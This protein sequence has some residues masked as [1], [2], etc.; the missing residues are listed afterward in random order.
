MHADAVVALIAIGAAASLAGM[1]WPFPR[2]PLGVA[3]NFAAGIVGALVGGLLG[4]AVVRPGAGATPDRM[5]FAAA[6]ALVVLLAI[7][8]VALRRARSA[9]ARQ[10]HP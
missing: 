7:H 3:L 10:R 1:I 5:L 4:F 9:H 6:G 2:G 8:A